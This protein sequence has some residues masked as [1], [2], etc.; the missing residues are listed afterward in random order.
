DYTLVK[1]RESAFEWLPPADGEFASAF[2][3]DSKGTILSFHLANQIRKFGKPFNDE[4]YSARMIQR[5]R[6]W[7]FNSIG[8]FTGLEFGAAARRG[9]HFP[10][11]AHLPLNEWEGI[12]RIPGIHETFDPFDE[13]TRTQ[14]EANLV[15]FLP[16]HAN[17]PLIIG[18]F[19][20]N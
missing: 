5:L 14:V 7:G 20:V 2:K 9:S 6:S 4:E 10:C 3:P 16:A 8:A 15:K 18:W 1:G 19:I 13:K 12:R 17:D 11:V